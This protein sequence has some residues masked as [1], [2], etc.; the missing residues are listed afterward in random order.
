MFLH[1]ATDKVIER[2]TLVSQGALGSAVLVLK[3]FRVSAVVVVI[4]ALFFTVSLL[5]EIRCDHD[6]REFQWAVCHKAAKVH[7][8]WILALILF[9]FF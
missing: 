8:V 3:F 4:V 2:L 7:L 5:V 6:G 9:P 1:S